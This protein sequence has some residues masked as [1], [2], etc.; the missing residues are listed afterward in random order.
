MI[1]DTG[2]SEIFG[3]GQ[4]AGDR[5]KSW[6]FSLWP[7]AVTEP[8]PW[9]RSVSFFFKAFDWIKPTHIMEGNL[10]YLMSTDFNVNLT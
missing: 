2:K 9:G 10:L 6:C 5:G 4:Q 7:K 8:L 3:V 1:V